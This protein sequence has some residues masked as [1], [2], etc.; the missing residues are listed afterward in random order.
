MDEAIKDILHYPEAKINTKVIMHVNKH[1]KI[2]IPLFNSPV[3]FKMVQLGKCP[4]L[5][6]WSITAEVLKIM[7]PTSCK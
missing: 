5:S 3:N 1:E 7:S 4:V 6:L 2:V